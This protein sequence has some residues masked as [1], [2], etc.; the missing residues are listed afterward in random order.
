MNLRATPAQL[1]TANA[2]F[3]ADFKSLGTGWVAGWSHRVGRF[4]PREMRVVLPDLGSVEQDMRL[5]L[6]TDR[7]QQLDPLFVAPFH[8]GQSFDRMSSDVHLIDEPMV[9]IAEHHEIR[10]VF[11]E[12]L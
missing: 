5:P 9:R 10:D 4:T 3:E 7:C 2:S 1:S 6:L 11:F 8:F 12:L